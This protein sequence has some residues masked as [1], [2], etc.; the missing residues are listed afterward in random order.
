MRTSYLIAGLIALLI[1]IWLGSGQV[2]AWNQPQDDAP[3]VAAMKGTISARAADNQA[4]LTV[5]ARLSN[6]IDL[7]RQ[8]S[9]NAQTQAIRTVTLRAGVVGEVVGLPVEIG[10][11]VT[12]GQLICELERADRAARVAQAQ[13]RVEQTRLIYEG[14]QRLKTQSF[15]SETALATARAD[16]A[17]AEA[18]LEAARVALADTRIRAP[19]DGVLEQRLVELGDYLQPGGACATL[20]DADP[21]LVVG[22][23]AEQDVR[24]LQVGQAGSAVLLDDARVEGS[25]RF[26]GTTA[27][28]ATRTFRVELQVDNPDL[29][30]RGGMTAKLE[31]PTEIARVHRVPTSLLTL[32][33]AGIVGLRIVDTDDRV[34]FHPVELVGDAAPGA[35]V[36]GLPDQANIITVG[37]ELVVDGDLVVVEQEAGSAYPGLADV[38]PTTGAAVGTL[39]RTAVNGG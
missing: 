11:R 29:R 14:N 34:R 28:N 18:E 12:K 27:R 1:L 20:V 19:F 4:A 24:R 7:T 23:V 13:A 37:H 15:Q 36:S 16:L 3:T 30:I 25:V 17:A 31:L 38:K 35:W 22:Q 2:A 5:R 9:V 10:T 6:A 21:M 26:V 8:V 32:D 33:D 39:P